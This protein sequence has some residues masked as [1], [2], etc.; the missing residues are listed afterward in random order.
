LAAG[1]TEVF[2]YRMSFLSAAALTAFGFGLLMVLMFRVMPSSMLR[3]VQKSGPD[4]MSRR[5]R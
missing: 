4:N 2:A 3:R 1:K 5:K